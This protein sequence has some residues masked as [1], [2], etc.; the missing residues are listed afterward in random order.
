MSGLAAGAA[1]WRNEFPEYF[2][3]AQKK[4]DADLF[5]EAFKCASTRF[6]EDPRPLF[7]Q[8]KMQLISEDIY[9]EWT[10]DDSRDQLLAIR[11]TANQ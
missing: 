10:S 5:D 2:L 4:F 1:R 3:A 9:T 8:P 6:S 7:Y 11:P